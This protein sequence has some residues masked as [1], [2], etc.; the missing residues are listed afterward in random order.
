VDDAG[1]TLEE[2]GPANADVCLHSDTE[3]FLHFYVK[4]IVSH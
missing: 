3:A 1:N 2:Q 4:Q